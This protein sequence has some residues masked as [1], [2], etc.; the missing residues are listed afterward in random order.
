M[1]IKKIV[2][3]LEN[4]ETGIK[5]LSFLR[6]IVKLINFLIPKK[7]NQIMFESIPDF[8][9]N[10]KALYDYMRCMGRKYEMIWAVNE[11]NDKF[12]IPQYKK[13]SLRQIW[14][15]LRSKYMVTSHGYH[16]PIKA[17]NQVFVNL[18]HGMPLKALSHVRKDDNFLLDSSNDKNYYLIAT[19]SVMRNA[20]AACFNQDPRRI[21]ITGQPR[22]DKLFKNSNK[23]LEKLLNVSLNDY[24][25]I[26][27]FLPTFRKSIEET[28]GELISHNFNL[29]DFNR[30][31]FSQFLQDNQILFIAKFHPFEESIAKPYFKKMDNTILITN[32]MLQK[33]FMDLY[34]ILSCAD[35][36]ITDYSSVY[37]DFLLLDKPIIF[38]VPDLDEYRKRRG[39][40]LEPFE[41][42]TPGPKVKNFEEFLKELE[43]CIKNPEYYS[44]ER[45]T[46]NNLVNYY[47]DDKS[48]ERIYKLVF[49]G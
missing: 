11:I 13:L 18:W 38:V 43:K 41:F 27:L 8:S 28:N 45:K 15:F 1:I 24:S 48:S 5:F 39:F 35:I 30:E 32:E 25:K 4:S 14:E 36:L 7:D 22:N 6:S 10:S 29:A 34:D 19:S 21:V 20:L 16:L 3:F 31:V 26:I 40:V 47:K 23:N 17:K 42:W 12:D 49:K 33:N 46:I 37:F 44:K 2:D 9:D